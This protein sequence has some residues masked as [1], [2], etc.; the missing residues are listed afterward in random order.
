MVAE[1][2]TIETDASAH[3]ALAVLC[4]IS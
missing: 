1:V 4:R 2:G 3:M